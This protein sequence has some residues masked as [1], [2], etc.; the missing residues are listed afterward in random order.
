MTSRS[1]SVSCGIGEVKG[2]RAAV[3]AIGLAPSGRAPRSEV[4]GCG[5]VVVVRIEREHPS[6]SR[7]SVLLFYLFSFSSTSWNERRKNKIWPAF[8]ASGRRGESGVAGGIEAVTHPSAPPFPSSPSVRG[9]HA[10]SNHR[11]HFYLQ[12]AMCGESRRHG[13]SSSPDSPAPSHQTHDLA[14]F[15]PSL[16][17]RCSQGNS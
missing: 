1:G 15:P 11:H 12:Q 2:E 4:C 7:F 5:G 10:R 8:F 6:L 13:L 14:P 3:V 9:Q 17:A 16:T